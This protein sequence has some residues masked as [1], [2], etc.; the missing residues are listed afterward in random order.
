MSI[1]STG[2]KIIR[3]NLSTNDILEA[4]SKINKSDI[5]EIGE[6]SH[7]VIKETDT[8]IGYIGDETL[9]LYDIDNKELLDYHNQLKKIFCSIDNKLSMN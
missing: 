6:L 7:I 5:F 8:P 4:Y 3:Y 2:Y 1:S 9:E